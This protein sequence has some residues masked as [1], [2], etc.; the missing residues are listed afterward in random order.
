LLRFC[1]RRFV[2][3]YSSSSSEVR[4][5]C[6]NLFA[7]Y[8][9]S[10]SLEACRQNQ[11][12]VQSHIQS[13]HMHELSERVPYG[14]DRMVP[15]TGSCKSSPDWLAPGHICLFAYSK[16]ARDLQSAAA[17]L[18]HETI[19]AHD[20]K[21]PLLSIIIIIIIIIH[22]GWLPPMQE[23]N[24]HGGTQDLMAF[25]QHPTTDIKTPLE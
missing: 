23:E 6:Q 25:F 14:N 4:W 19:T 15:P 12:V 13:R 1:R 2:F 11:G 21:L 24:N 3:F 8:F 9:P 22:T 16:Q 5:L 18:G 17:T 10:F 7:Y 20:P